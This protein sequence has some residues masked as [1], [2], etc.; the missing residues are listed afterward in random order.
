MPQTALVQGV[1]SFG[2]P[3]N[4]YAIYIAIAT[5]ESLHWNDRK[6]GISNFANVGVDVNGC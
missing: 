2:E 4:T 3:S 1:V 5:D 6:A